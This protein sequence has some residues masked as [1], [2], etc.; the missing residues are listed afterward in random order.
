MDDLFRETNQ[1]DNTLGSY[2]ATVG[3]CDD[4]ND[5]GSLK[6]MLGGVDQIN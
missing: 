4:E 3:Y 1:P 5:L 6:W 2:D